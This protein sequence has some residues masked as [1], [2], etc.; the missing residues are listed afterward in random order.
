[1]TFGTTKT[2][3]LEFGNIPNFILTFSIVKYE[4]F[5]IKFSLEEPV[6]SEISYKAE[7]AYMETVNTSDRSVSVDIALV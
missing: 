4:K 3:S 7:T 2:L 6:T 5:D 1:M